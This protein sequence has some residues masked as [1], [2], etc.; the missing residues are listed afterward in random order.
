LIRI[1]KK[2][3]FFDSFCQPIQNGL[4]LTI[5]VISRK[6]KTYKSRAYDFLLKT[7]DQKITVMKKKKS[8]L[9]QKLAALS[10]RVVKQPDI[11][12]CHD[13]LSKLA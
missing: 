3:R 11:L 9:W 10:L 8:R 12:R 4:G 13:S 2:K 1:L 6:E 5:L 7:Y